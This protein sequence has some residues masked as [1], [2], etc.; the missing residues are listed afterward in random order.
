MRYRLIHRSSAVLGLLACV[1]SAPACNPD[2]HAATTVTA[3][4][5]DSASEAAGSWL[6]HGGTFAETRYSPLASIHADNVD[7]LGLAWS[8]DFP[9]RGGVEA[10]PLM[11]DGVLYLSGPWSTVYALDARSGA[12]L[13]RYDPE[14]PR[15]HGLLVCCGMVNR[16]VA[17]YEGKVFVG[18][19]DGRLVALDQDTGEPVWETPTADPTMGYSITGAPRVVAGNVVIGNGGAEFGV[20]G[21][22]SAYD[23]GTGELVWRTYTVP[24]NPADGFESAAMEYAAGTWTGE[25]WRYGGGGTVWDSFAYD[26]DLDLLYV[27]AGN[28]S[29]WN[30]MIRSPEG[31]DNLFLASILALRPGNGELVW[32]YQTTPG[33]T[34]DYTATQHMILA[35]LEI[36]GE[37]R[38]VLMQAPK[39]GFFYVLDR[40]TGE[41]ISAEPFV[42]VNWARH[43]D[44]ETGRPVELPEAR[45]EDAPFVMTPGV[46]GGHN[47][48]PMSYNPETGLVY[49][50]AQVHWT[51]YGH[52]ENFEFQ[53]GVMNLGV[54]SPGGPLPRTS[55]HL[56]AWD[57]VA[58]EERWRVPHPDMWN[59]GT[60]T[61]A[62][63]LVFQGRGDGSFAAYDA[64]DGTRLWAFSS[65][66]GII[67]PPITYELDGIQYVTV[68]AGWSGPGRR[69][70]SPPG[71]AANYEQRGRLMS[72]ALDRDEARPPLS[73]RRPLPSLADLELAGLGLP[74]DPASVD[75]GST[76]FQSNCAL[77]HGGNADAQGSMPSLIRM[78]RAS[79]RAF[80][81]IVGQGSLERLGM[82]N[83]GDRLTAEEITLIHAWL[84]SQIHAAVDG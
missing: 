84:V 4:R 51:R 32:Y 34:W 48:H 17:L 66:L 53:E 26:P 12:L 25:W 40:A 35:E 54:A 3:K 79:H 55:G 19:L 11:S 71:E 5:L 60:L 52:D 62:G 47:W 77:C 21:Y 27:G 16:G 13:W 67:A 1:L 6:T 29:P 56:L 72:F 49:I 64:R 58:Q 9:L 7:R 68:A 43:V 42:P 57:P 82:P 61:T 30:R 75:R 10:T 41:L 73:P 74:E 70:G 23:A 31:G 2:G 37:E 46:L 83:F 8:Y 69:A 36:E 59:G 24:G 28:G 22:V 38:H 65:G 78:A 44:L 18:T 45:Y 76:L 80:Q 63:N 15:L 39:N 20:R 14:V 33:E 81:Q 50:P